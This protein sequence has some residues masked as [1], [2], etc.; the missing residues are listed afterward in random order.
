MKGNKNVLVSILVLAFV[1]LN[2]CCT[3]DAEK[4]NSVEQ[5][6]VSKE[7]LINQY[8]NEILDYDLIK[9]NGIVPLYSQIDKVEA[10]LGKPTKI[11]LINGSTCLSE[12]HGLN[13]V[14]VKKM[15]F[16]K[17]MFENWGNKITLIEIDFEST[18]ITLIH[19]KISINKHTTRSDL[20]EIF[21][22][23]VELSPAGN[24]NAWA[25]V[26]R[27]SS[28]RNA[29]AQWHLIFKGGKFTKIIFHLS[30]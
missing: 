5:K 17:S 13:P 16:G 12:K 6:N 9:I 20:H 18:D 26:V 11:E 19:P 24:G 23:S 30:C 10:I 8:K 22:L 28:H 21:P 4:Q 2:E 27:I 25:G 3:N 14:K 1:L 29:E 15:Y 7:S